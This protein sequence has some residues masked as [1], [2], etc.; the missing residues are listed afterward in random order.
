[1]Y[2]KLFGNADFRLSGRSGCNWLPDALNR[3]YNCVFIGD[4][5]VLTGSWDDVKDDGL[6]R[7]VLDGTTI[8]SYYATKDDITGVWSIEVDIT[9]LLKDL[10]EPYTAWG[11]TINQSKPT[12]TYT[13]RTLSVYTENTSSVSCYVDIVILDGHRISGMPHPYYDEMLNFAQ[14]DV[15]YNGRYIDRVQPPNVV[16]F[17][18]QRYIATTNFPIW[19]EC[20]DHWKQMGEKMFS[21]VYPNLSNGN[22]G[23]IGIMINSPISWTGT[24]ENGTYK[25]NFIDIDR[26]DCQL[27]ALVRWKSKTGNWRQ[28]FFEVKNITDNLDGSTVT[29]N[30]G[31]S[32]RSLVENSYQFDI[33]ISGLTRY[34]LWYYQD[35]LSSDEIYCCVS[36][37]DLG[38]LA[39]I[40]NAIPDELPTS[41]PSELLCSVVNPKKYVVPN[42]TDKLYDF[43]CTLKYKKT[44]Y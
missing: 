34:G 4:K 22:G 39:N 17:P 28:H 37:D 19:I 11:G 42:G 35:I 16:L 38:M 15:L 43:D 12:K 18:S 8:G 25:I 7:L 14:E 23:S 36:T 44:S 1:M 9:Y 3:V 40:G 21:Y 41:G 6:L 30:I 33:H 29:D 32:Y 31:T 13:Q 2:I 5:V 20:C 10:K 27:H 26:K 24:N